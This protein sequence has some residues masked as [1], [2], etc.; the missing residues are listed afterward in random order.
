MSE[1]I[2]EQREMKWSDE[3]QDEEEEMPEP[4]E[5][6]YRDGTTKNECWESDR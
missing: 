1:S 3:I 6:S 5:E 2:R 4:Y